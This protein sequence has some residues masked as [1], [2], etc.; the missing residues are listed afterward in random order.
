[1]PWLEL[2]A[3]AGARV[4]SS[5]LSFAGEWM[6]SYLES[7]EGPSVRR[8]MTPTG[9]LEAAYAASIVPMHLHGKTQVK[10]SRLALARTCCAASTSVL[11]D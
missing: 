7:P 1:M 6:D 11:P 9:I 3:T 4:A 5:G 8:P 10:T 2:I